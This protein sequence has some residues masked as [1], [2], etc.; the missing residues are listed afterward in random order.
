MAPID[1]AK[2]V[3]SKEKIHDGQES[4]MEQG[5]DTGQTKFKILVLEPR[6][7]RLWMF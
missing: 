7:A 1:N 5:S 4:K 2:Y 3:N 6:A